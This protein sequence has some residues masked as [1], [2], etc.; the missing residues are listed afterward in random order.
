VKNLDSD[1]QALISFQRGGVYL[2]SK[3]KDGKMP[4]VMVDLPVVN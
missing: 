1:G 2:D 3:W 4:K